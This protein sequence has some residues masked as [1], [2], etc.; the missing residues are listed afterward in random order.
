MHDKNYPLIYLDLLAIVHAM[1]N[2]WHYQ[3]GQTFE[4][5]TNHKSLR[6][7]FSQT[8]LNMHQRCQDDFLQ[9]LNF[10]IKFKIGKENLAI[11]ALSKKAQ[12]L[13]ITLITNLLL[14]NIHRTLPQ[15]SYFR[16]IISKLSS[17]IAL[18]TYEDYV[19]KYKLLN[20]KGKLGIHSILRSQVIREAQESPLAAHLGYQKMLSSLRINFFWPKLKK[21]ALEYAKRCLVCQKVKG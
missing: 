7:I 10:D 18:P 4:L 9:E 1:K 6:W 15:G 5:G 12:V 17:Q 20:F 21:D 8:E 16:E 11:D 19:F 14:E 13:T 3:L 2:W